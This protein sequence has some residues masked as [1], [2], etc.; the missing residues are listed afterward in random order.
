MKKK[1]ISRMELDKY[2]K[3]ASN[4]WGN[5]IIPFIIIDSTFTLANNIRLS[6]LKETFTGIYSEYLYKNLIIEHVHEDKAMEE[7][8]LGCKPYNS[9]D[10]STVFGSYPPIY[11]TQY[12]K[13]IK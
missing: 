8:L 10:M 9:G 3:E 11:T 6:I 1:L 13:E 4:R 5:N 12:V 2:I 7:P